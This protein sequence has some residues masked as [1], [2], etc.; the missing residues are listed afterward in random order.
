MTFNSP[1]AFILLAGLPFIIEP[2]LISN[3][4]S[5][6]NF[7]LKAN[8]KKSTSRKTGEALP[9]SSLTTLPST[10]KSRSYRIVISLLR[11]LAYITLVFAL[12]RPQVKDSVSEIIESG[13]DIM[14]VLDA[15][16]SMAALDFTLENKKVERMSALK[17]VVQSFISERQG[18]R[19]GLIVFGDKAFVQC[20]LTLDTKVLVE[21]VQSLEVGMAGDATAMGDSIAI[22][23]KR[24]KEIESASKILVLITDGYKT[25]GSI[26]PLQAAEIAKTLGVKVYTIGIGGQNRAPFRTTNVF[27]MES[28]QYKDVPLDE[29]TLR[30]I[31]SSTGGVYFNAAN[32]EELFSV[33]KE[34]DKIEKR[35]SN[36]KEYTNLEEKFSTLAIL[37]FI[38]IVIT[39]LLQVFFYKSLV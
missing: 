27:G 5:F 4:F 20:P 31:A 34:I 28:I 29:K 11:A 26:E 25:A 33:Y 15:S 18:D 13:R 6:L 22:A 30:E 7:F 17:H 12:A 14:F 24:M 16:R 21:Y 10:F 38:L 39:E 8:S 32:T 35:E 2:G 1:F 37:A 3:K 9:F 19:M 36:V 23:L